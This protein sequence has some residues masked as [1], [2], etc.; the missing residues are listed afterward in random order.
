[1]TKKNNLLHSLILF[2]KDPELK[3]EVMHNLVDLLG[4]KENSFHPLVF[5]NGTPQIG[6]NVYIGLF[7]EINAKGGQVVIG[8]NCDIASFVSIN[9]ADSHLKCIGLAEE[10]SRNTVIFEENVFI[11]SHSFIGGNVSIGHHS[12]IAAGTILVNAGEIPP[13]SLIVGN[14]AQIKKGYYLSNNRS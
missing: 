8:D 7:S 10:I 9:V 12:V 6:E 2:N 5:I 1:M 13:Y 3:R 11:G 4:L 14:P